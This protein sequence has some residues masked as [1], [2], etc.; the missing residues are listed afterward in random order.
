M[1]T[2][3]TSGSKGTGTSTL[4]KIVLM[5]WLLAVLPLTSCS[6]NELPNASSA[7][8]S[9]LY[10]PPTVTLKEG[11]LYEFCEGSLVG[12]KEHKFH[13]DYSYRRA[14]IIGEK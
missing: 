11:Q 3:N 9:A 10:D 6:W 8:A 2:S 12:R 14:V 5:L 1:P 4:L 7:N 13:S